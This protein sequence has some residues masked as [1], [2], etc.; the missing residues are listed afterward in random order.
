M[1]DLHKRTTEL[2][3]WYVNGALS[4]DE[5]AALE[6]HLGECIPCRA[7]LREEQ[8]ICALVR[9][10]DDIPLSAEHGISDLMTRIDHKTGRTSRRPL[11][12]QFAWGLAIACIVLVGSLL[13]LRAPT[14]GLNQGDGTFTTL[15]QSQ[16]G[17]SGRIDIVLSAG[18]DEAEIENIIQAFGGRL[19]D[20]PSELGRYTVAVPE[21]EGASTQDVIDALSGDPRVRFVSRNF[22]ASPAPAEDE[23]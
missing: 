1:S 22:I 6:R 10:Q 13:L 23:R 9:E 12:P 18:T 8:R 16:P 19:V 2:L 14:P 17:T 20:G 15:T 21:A 3:P 11:Q 7:A 5:T 4:P